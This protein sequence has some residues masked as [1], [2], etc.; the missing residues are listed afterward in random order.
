MNRFIRCF[1]N[2]LLHMQTDLVRW[3]FS[4]IHIYLSPSHITPRN[5]IWCRAFKK[6]VRFK[7]SFTKDLLIDQ[8]TQMHRDTHHI[9]VLLNIC[10]CCPTQNNKFRAN[11]DNLAIKHWSSKAFGT[12][13]LSIPINSMMGL[14]NATGMLLIWPR[15][16]L[17]DR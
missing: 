10:R 12:V 1:T 14:I 9:P 2:R 3:K 4:T 5:M 7:I 11:E 6:C 15:P 16:F 8:Q 13:S 17:L